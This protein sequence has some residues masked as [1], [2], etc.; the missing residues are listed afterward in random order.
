MSIL[1]E[2]SVTRRRF[3]A[4]SRG[5]DG[6]WAEGTPTDS[7]ILAAVQ[8]AS[9]DD[10]AILPEGE[11]SKRARRLYTVSEL[12]V[13]DVVGGTSADHVQAEGR[14]W[15]VLH[16]EQQRNVIPHYKAIV[17]ALQETE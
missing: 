9:G 11:R 12:R 13:V 6:R 7:T 10:L 16:V 17:V 3:A 1:G 15:K 8:P 4:G 2:E 5:T 14:W